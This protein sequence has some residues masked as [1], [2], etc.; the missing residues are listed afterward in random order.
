MRSLAFLLTGNVISAIG[1]RMSLLA[2]PWFVL[3]TTGSA[4][5]TGIVAAAET[6]PYVIVCALGGP[7]MDRIGMKRA[8]VSAD[9]LSA[10][11]FTSIPLLHFGPGLSFPALTGLIALAGMLR[12]VSD[13]AKTVL[14]R[15]AVLAS[16]VNVARATSI[17]DGLNRLSTLLGAPLGGL[18]IA[19]TDAP[20]V[21]LIDAATF[22][23]GAIIIGLAVRSTMRVPSEEESISYLDTLRNG[24]AFIRGDSLIAAI[25]VLVLFTNLFDAAYSSVLLPLWAAEVVQSPVALGLAAAFFASAA[26]LGNIVFTIVA[27]Y[28]PRFLLFAVGFLV[29]GA[30]R[31]FAAA[32]GE[33]VW[34]LYAVSFVA[35]LGIAAINPILGAVI[36]ERVPGHMQARVQGLTSAVVWAGIPVGALLG[37]WLGE[38]S[39]KGAM[40]ICGTGYLLVTLW[41]FVGTPWRQLTA[42]VPVHGVEHAQ[43]DPDGERSG[44]DLHGLEPGRAPAGVGGAAAAAREHP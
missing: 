25:L 20:T 33:G 42:K 14:F 15:E 17:N 23:V 6:I 24:W 4:A 34:P 28:A 9:V 16:K 39:V 37:G 43:A 26:V 38:W 29:G 10:L 32:F 5:K 11:I 41:P 1:S 44:Q 3:A 13:T 30:P 36:F 31:F 19:A 7:L 21:L 22:A 35:G 8:S 27:P 12:G 40:V 18:L 2:L